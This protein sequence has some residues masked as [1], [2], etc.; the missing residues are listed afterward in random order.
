MRLKWILPAVLIAGLLAVVVPSFLRAWRTPGESGGV[1]DIRT[2]LAAESQYATA[3]GGYFDL[4]SCL[5]A[6]PS[7][8][9][10]KAAGTAEPLLDARL[11]ALRPRTGYSFSFVPGP[12]ANPGEGRQKE[13]S[14][15]S[16]TAYAVVALPLQSSGQRRAFCG[17]STGRICARGD[18]TIPAV[19]NGRCPQ[20]C[21]TL[22]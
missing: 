5:A 22:H 13:V 3:N 8:L 15:S 19:E 17:D 18:G 21:E 10:G 14:K 12:P 20:A 1:G 4:P 16:L 6:P 11:G 2:I 7:C 9:P